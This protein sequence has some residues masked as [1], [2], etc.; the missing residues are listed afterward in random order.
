MIKKDFYIAELISRYLSGMLS[1]EEEAGLKEWRESSPE[2]EELFRH[3]CDT[4]N[5]AEYCRKSKCFDKNKAWIQLE[6]QL[7]SIRR[8]NMFLK[9]GK[10][11]ALLI[12][13]AMIVFSVY[14]FNSGEDTVTER[15]ENQK[16]QILPGEKKATLTL[17]SGETID[18]Q[19]NSNA[20]LE[21]KD[22]TAITIDRDAL[23]YQS[24]DVNVSEEKEIC[25]KIDVPLG[26]EYALTLS[27]G[28]K[29]YLNAMSS[30]Q[31]PV[32]F[33]KDQRVVILEGEG[34]FE[35]AENA[36][37]FIVKV[38]KIDVEVLGTTFN[39]SA[40][41]GESHQTTLVEG[42]LR[43]S[44]VSGLSETLKS[45]EQAYMNNDSG[46][47]KIRKVDVSQYI[48]WV[49]GKI[50]FKDACLEDIMNNL[51][52]WYDIRVSYEDAAV[53]KLRFGCNLNRYKEITPFL[54][55]LEKTEKVNIVV[56]GNNI[57]FKHK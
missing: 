45:S 31:F 27:D 24:A 38:G 2:N 21:E 56:K 35:V 48:S 18:L 13:P 29:V 6:H 5:L 23:N 15:L 53:K 49:N 40:Y 51:A 19:T 12:I 41:E 3:I 20:K 1:S 39:V 26:G 17:G 36:K 30:L 22:G 32:R 4:E 9:L 25:N 10:Y 57:I 7:S 28:T 33:I 55:L 47:L 46:E 11:A 34:Y 43:V 8:R 52:R 14:I 44:T 37:P 50:Y 42:S 16:I 54:E